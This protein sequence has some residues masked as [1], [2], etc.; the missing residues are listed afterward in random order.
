[1]LAGADALH[2]ELA[3]SNGGATSDTD[4]SLAGTAREPV[5]AVVRK[6]TACEFFSDE[7]T[8]HLL[9]SRQVEEH[10]EQ[11]RAVAGGEQEAVTEA[12]SPPHGSRVGASCSRSS[13]CRRPP[14]RY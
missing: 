12:L 13:D 2:D 11:Y 5:D 6:P 1:V 14:W 4:L 9:D 3:L 8:V 7:G 10:V